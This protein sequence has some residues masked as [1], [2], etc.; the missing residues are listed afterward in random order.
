MILASGR[1]PAWNAVDVVTKKQEIG[2]LIDTLNTG[3]RKP[4][5][6]IVRIYPA[7]PSELAS[8]HPVVYQ[9]RGRAK[10]HNKCFLNWTRRLR[11]IAAP[12]RS[13]PA[14]AQAAKPQS[15]ASSLGS[16]WVTP[17]F[18]LKS[19]PLIVPRLRTQTA[20]SQSSLRSP[21]QSSTT[22]WP[23]CRF[24]RAVRST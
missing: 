15:Q 20:M 4:H 5:Q 23:F 24:G 19:P 2:S 6:G 7:R 18:V 12:N 3:R 21:V 16:P 13:S 10:V 14:H 17:T 9:A 8:S 11:Q 22:C 1:T